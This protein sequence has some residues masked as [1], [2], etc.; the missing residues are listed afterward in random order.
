MVVVVGT[1]LTSLALALK[2]A[3]DKNLEDKKRM[4]ILASIN[5][6]SD[7]KTAATL[8]DEHLVRTYVIDFYGKE[9]ATDADGEPLDAF[10]IDIKKDYKD[11][12]LAPNDKYYPVFE[13]TKGDSIFHVVPMVGTGLWGPIWGYVSLG[14]DNIT[15]YGAS[16]DHKTETPGLGAEIKEDF[17]EVLW[18]GQKIYNITEGREEFT[19]IAVKKGNANGSLHAV[20]GIT[21]GTITSNGV[22]EMAKRTFSIYRFN[23]PPNPEN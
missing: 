4:D 20:D 11:K 2:P 7:R 9:V 16:F 10:E 17:F 21:G 18:K 3:Q 19:S 14:S 22:D 1:I 5:V 6:D 13:M 15:V 8:Y 12:S 23:L